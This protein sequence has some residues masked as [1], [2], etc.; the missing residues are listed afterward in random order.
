MGPIRSVLVV[1]G[2][3]AGWLSAAYLHRALGKNVTVTLV[4][5]PNIPRIGVGEATVSTLKNTM[6]FLGFDE[7][8]WMPHVGATYKTAV[9]FEQWN[10]PVSEGREHFYH[11]F[12][13]HRQ[14]PMVHPLP[15][16][17]LEVGDG[18]SLMH[19]WHAR[20]LA[21]DPT[22]YAYA[23]F[24]G[25][26]IC[27]ARKAPYFDGAS[28]WAIPTAYHLDAHK[29]AAFMTAKI[30]ERGVRHLRDDVT[31]VRRD[32]AGF[33]AG[34]VT[35]DHGELTADLYIDCTGFRSVLL[36]KTLEEPFDSAATYLWNDSAV[37][38]RPKNAPGDLEPYTLARASDAG[39]MWNIPLYHRSG[40]GYV[41]SSRYKSKDEA[42]RE[43]RGYLGDR[44]DEETPANH[45]K[46]TPGRYRRAWVK[47]CVAIGL[48]A[49][50][51]EPLESTT[52][53]LIE[54][55]LGN[56]LSLLPD[57]GFDAARAQRYNRIVGQMFDEVRDFIVLHFVLSKRRDTPYWRDL[58]ETRAVPDSLAEHLEFFRA[59]MPLG[60]RFRNFVFRE[61]SYAC[62]MSGLGHLPS[63]PHP[64]LAHVGDEEA[65]AAFAEM[66]ERSKDL[67][68]RLPGHRAYLERAYASAGFD[69]LG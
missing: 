53:F 44:A 7:S 19:Y 22:P 48:A 67:A 14:E 5:S 35:K 60:E 64:L 41:Y 45:L 16:W 62:L 11:P 2:G 37:A 3:T 56:L 34:I 57:R 32:S 30:V 36:G 29:F 40:T 31:T 61:R 33:I 69:F 8:D 26:A 25:P 39:W 42:E 54:Y 28:D 51:I 20:K 21:G 6:A 23:V 68:A 50:F 4:E 55:A 43:I 66:A 49:N 9:R 15:T 27:D 18:I 10:R 58:C 65:N 47:N 38:M 59:S 46:F 13:E 52:I 24:P 63:S 12:F 1:G 17:L